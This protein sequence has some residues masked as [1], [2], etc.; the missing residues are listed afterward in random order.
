MADNN[1]A[2]R[3]VR[4]PA[5][6]RTIASKTWPRSRR[7]WGCIVRRQIVFMDR[8]GVHIDEHWIES[9]GRPLAVTEV[10]EIF[11]VPEPDDFRRVAAPTT[12]TA[13]GAL[14]AAVVEPS[15]TVRL[16]A[17]LA[18]VAVLVATLARRYLRA[19]HLCLWVYPDGHDGVLVAR[20][21]EMFVN[22]VCRA[23]T[24]ARVWNGL[25]APPVYRVPAR[26]WLPERTAVSH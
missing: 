24:R 25:P 26:R 6:G 5:A 20:D 12:V 19:D 13:A 14:V 7:N 3:P 23:L 10:R 4:E 16:A 8:G 1:L 18:V 22:Q 21:G 11:V 15:A 2:R 9:G 17:G